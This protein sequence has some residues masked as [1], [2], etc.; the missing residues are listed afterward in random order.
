MIGPVRVPAEGIVKLDTN[1][2]Q[3]VRESLLHLVQL[4]HSGT[5]IVPARVRIPDLDERSSS[6]AVLP[7][8]VLPQDHGDAA[9][10]VVD[11]PYVP[12]PMKVARHN[13][14]KFLEASQL[15]F[16]IVGVVLA[17]VEATWVHLHGDIIDVVPAKSVP[18]LI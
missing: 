4:D 3:A 18:E 5:S 17:I 11:E 1:P 14:A 13:P 12:N 9:H 2:L 16:E 8:A 15:G 10:A 7:S 6:S